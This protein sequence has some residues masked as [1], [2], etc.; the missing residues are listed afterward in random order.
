MVGL[1]GLL[2]ME[3]ELLLYLI[4]QALFALLL[5]AATKRTHI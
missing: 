4:D 1:S 2:G 3:H 5:H